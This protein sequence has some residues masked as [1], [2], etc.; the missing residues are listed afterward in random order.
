M[1]KAKE[2]V[3]DVQVSLWDGTTFSGQLREPELS[4]KLASGV[5]IKVPIALLEEYSQPQP[6]PSALMLEKIKSL[7][8][9]LNNDD[10]HERD[11][12]QAALTAM[13]PVAQSVLKQMR[14]DQPAE[15]QKTIDLILQKF[16]E[17]R[18]K[19]KPG[20]PNTAPGGAPVNG[21]EFQPMLR[22]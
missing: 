12:A 2:S 7:V 22:D 15:A 9:Q 10:W 18:K 5:Q 21:V 20:A 1:S 3:Q 11:R 19:N 14:P 17:Q 16:E 8:A 13:G 4:C 6:Q